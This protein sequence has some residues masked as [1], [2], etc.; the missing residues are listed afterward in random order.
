M[1]ITE[2]TNTAVACYNMYSRQ[3]SVS[4]IGFCHFSTVSKSPTKA[5]PNV[6]NIFQYIENI[7][8]ADMA[9]ILLNPIVINNRNCFLSKLISYM[10]IG[11]HKW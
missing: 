3:F 1:K 4:T 2:S 5:N 9:Y 11:H 7:T 6:Q 8:S 10:F